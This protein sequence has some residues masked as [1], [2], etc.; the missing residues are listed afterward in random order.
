VPHVHCKTPETG[1]TSA[2]VPG[3]AGTPI[4]QEKTTPDAN[5]K[6]LY[7]QLAENEL[8]LP[9]RAGEFDQSGNSRGFL[10]E[11]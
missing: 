1:K 4:T 2:Q 10:K 9:H 6:R 7:C 11:K 5:C 3:R 8:L